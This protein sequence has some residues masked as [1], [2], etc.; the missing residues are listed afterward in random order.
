LLKLKDASDTQQ[1]TSR[2][3]AR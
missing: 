3:T 1:I 2:C